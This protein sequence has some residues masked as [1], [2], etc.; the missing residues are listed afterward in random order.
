MLKKIITVIF[1]LYWNMLLFISNVSAINDAPSVNCTGLPWCKMSN[2]T[3]SEKMWTEE[4]SINWIWNVIWEAIQYVAV[5]AVI[6]LM[7]AWLFYIF[8]GGEEEKTKKAKSWIIW[9]LA[10]VLISVSA[11]WIINMLN[12]INIW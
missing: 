10:W 6:S 7:L 1:V 11:W 2:F 3:D 4:V 5:M 12:E 9:S 8:S